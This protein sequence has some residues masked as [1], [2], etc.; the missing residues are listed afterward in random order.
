MARRYTLDTK[1]DAL[2]QLDQCDGDLLRT[3]DT[4]D[5]PARTLRDWRNQEDDLRDAYNAKQRRH[6]HRLKADLQTNM[7]ERGMAIVARMDDETLDNAPLNQ[8]TSALG[9]LVNHALKLEEVIDETD[10]QEEKEHI[11]RFEYYYD[12]EI[13]DAPPWAN[14]SD[15]TSSEIQSSRLREKM[16][17]DTSGQT[18]HNGADLQRR[19][20]WL[21]VDSN[22]SDGNTDVA[23]DEQAMESYRERDWYHD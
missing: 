19:D 6:L 22:A 9:S 11:V 5:I 4:L 8:L 10:E 7:L 20:T 17:Q 23:R 1:I 18:A 12:G 2:N 13:H 3:S 16:G 15:E 21:V 14:D